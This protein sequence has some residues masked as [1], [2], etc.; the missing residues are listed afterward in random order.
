MLQLPV[1]AIAGGSGN[2]LA[3]SLADYAG[4]SEDYLR[5]PVL[6]T[7]L[8]VARGRVIPVNL[9]GILHNH[10]EFCNLYMMINFTFTETDGSGT[11]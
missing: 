7:S 10:E 6:S 11:K 8:A 1:G 4:E 5:H 3:R 2:G 9:V